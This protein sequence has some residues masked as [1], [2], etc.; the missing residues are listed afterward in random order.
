M[1]RNCVFVS[2]SFK[3]KY[4]HKEPG[5]T[6]PL[7]RKVSQREIEISWQ[8]NYVQKV[9]L[10]TGPN[11]QETHNLCFYFNIIVPYYNIIQHTAS[12]ITRTKF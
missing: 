9:Y 1:V 7:E 8:T 10:E 3:S 12:I 5:K 4:K 2:L 11:Y 6:S